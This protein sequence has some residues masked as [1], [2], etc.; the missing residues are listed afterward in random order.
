[1]E[2][3]LEQMLEV[4][5]NIVEQHMTEIDEALNK[6][7]ELGIYTVARMRDETVKALRSQANTD[8]DRALYFLKD[9]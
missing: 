8:P 6:I 7:L 3:R 9:T 5:Q 4:K 2:F 1:M